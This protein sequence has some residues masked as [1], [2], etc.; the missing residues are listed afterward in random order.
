MG[1]HVWEDVCGVWEDV[2]CECMCPTCKVAGVGEQMLT[3]RL[4]T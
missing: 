1:G 4:G 3:S 2:L